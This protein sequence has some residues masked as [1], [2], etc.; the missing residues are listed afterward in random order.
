MGKM[1]KKRKWRKQNYSAKIIHPAFETIA[2][3]SR[4]RI[5]TFSYREFLKKT[6]IWRRYADKICK[7][8]CPLKKNLFPICFKSTIF[9][10][11]ENVKVV[12]GL[13]D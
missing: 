2:L 1:G 13:E 6:K 7:P 11:K 8:I 9:K 12:F 4:D 5:F 10:A 3:S